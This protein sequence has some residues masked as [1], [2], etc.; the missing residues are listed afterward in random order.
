MAI[1]SSNL[2]LALTNRM[3]IDTLDLISNSSEGSSSDC[4]V[5]LHSGA[6]PTAN[7]LLNDWNSY[8]WP[9]S[10]FLGGTACVIS[11]VD[12]NT[13]SFTINS[14]VTVTGNNNGTATWAVLWS[15]RTADTGGSIVTRS[16]SSFTSTIP[17]EQFFVVPVSDITTTTGIVRMND[18]NIT[19][20]SASTVSD[21]T[22]KIG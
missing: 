12:T 14:P 21:I 1:F 19:V 18:T 11:L 7:D 3:I 6:Q 16:T 5:T 9:A 20:G 15:T 8:R 4:F 22:F 10:S 13:P 2:A 17:T